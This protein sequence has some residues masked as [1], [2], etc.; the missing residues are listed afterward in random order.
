MYWYLSLQFGP[1]LFTTIFWN[2]YYYSKFTHSATVA[3]GCVQ[4]SHEDGS[5]MRDDDRF[6]EVTRDATTCQLYYDGVHEKCNARCNY[7]QNARRSPPFDLLIFFKCNFNF[8]QY[9]DCAPFLIMPTLSPLITKLNLKNVIRL[10][11]K[12]KVFVEN[13]LILSIQV[14]LGFTFIFGHF[15]CICVYNLDAINQTVI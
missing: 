3:P 6:S 9:S 1:A 11:F 7:K 10:W 8:L 12:Y 5:T 14:N 13:I 2:V 4:R 15:L